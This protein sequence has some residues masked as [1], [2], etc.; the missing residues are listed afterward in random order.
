MAGIGE[1]SA[2]RNKDRNGLIMLIINE[3]EVAKL[4]RSKR[5]TISLEISHDANLIVRAPMRASLREIETIV[6]D[7][8]AWI[9]R[10]KKLAEQRWREA[11]PKQFIDNENFL[12]LGELY[13][14]KVSTTVKKPLMFNHGFE[15]RQS[16]IVNAKKLFIAW[17]RQRAREI[18]TQRASHF[19]A[20]M[21]LN[22]QKIRISS[23]K[24]NWGSCG[25]NGTLSFSWRLIL[26]PLPVIDYVVAHE[27][28]HLR[29]FN[30]SKNFWKTVAK[31]VV[32]Y[33][34]HRRW[35]RDHGH[36]LSI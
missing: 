11:L 27:L 18:L 34:A 12:F 31:M 14:L 15:L 21:Q 7:K 3:I 24:S 9:I 10:Q 19:A 5:R 26:A 29:H 30:H 1:D 20:L 23:A 4:V 6:S 13:P 36:R 32:D 17:Y 33:E 25:R 8:S 2:G 16:M 28:A 22:F 35:L